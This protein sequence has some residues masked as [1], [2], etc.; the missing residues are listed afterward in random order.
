MNSRSSRITPSVSTNSMNHRHK[1]TPIRYSENVTTDADN[2]HQHQMQP[3]INCN[4]YTSLQN[5]YNQA[6]NNWNQKCI[7]H[8]SVLRA[9]NAKYNVLLQANDECNRRYKSLNI[10]NNALSNACDKYKEE[11]VALREQ[12]QSV[13]NQW[14]LKRH[15]EITAMQSILTECDAKLQ[16]RSDE[17]N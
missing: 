4:Q 8:D 2:P 15:T 3:E 1:C 12:H 5:Q 16:H 11:I 10:R 7:Q 9:W 6:I 13:L 14:S 17:Y